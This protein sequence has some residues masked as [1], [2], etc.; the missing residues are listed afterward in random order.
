MTPL[1]LKLSTLRHVNPWMI[2]ILILIASVGFLM[3]YSAA[4]GSMAP[5]AWKQIF[6][7]FVGSILM[8]AVATTD[9]RSWMSYAY[10][11]YFV[12]LLL[13]IGVEVMGFIGMGAQRWIDLYIIQ[14]QPS[15]IMKIALVLALAR[16]FH[17]RTLVEIRHF[18]TLL[19]PLA[20]ILMPTLLVMR[21]PDL[22][23]A[24]ILILCGATLFF[25]AGVQWWKFAIAGGGILAATP[26]IWM[27]L[28]D[29]QKNR[30]LTFINPENDPTNSGYHV[31]QSKIALGSGGIMG[32]GFLQGTQS[33]LNFLPE[34]QTDF[35]FTMFSEEF[36]LIGGIILL[37]LYAAL[38]AYGFQVAMTSRSSFG[39]LVAIGMTTIVFLYVFINVAMVMGMLP[40]VG[41]PLPF[42]SYGGTALL[43]LLIGQG[44]VLSIAIHHHNRIGRNSYGNK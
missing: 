44:M 21:Q 18:P 41:V 33:H 7:F 17:K 27:L 26:A 19:F 36:G 39:R 13:I 2:G 8:I 42:V 32:K 24:V 30:V 6:R 1:I 12:A 9:S 15:E 20:L 23:T 31:S 22:G 34:K 29:Y 40:V 14:L 43:T 10:P 4:N 38:I 35:I 3:L 25:V 11:L 5:W 37:G 28:Y 16:Y